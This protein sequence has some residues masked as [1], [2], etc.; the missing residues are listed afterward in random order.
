MPDGRG[1]WGKAGYRGPLEDIPGGMG[2]TLSWEGRYGGGAVLLPDGRVVVIGGI[3]I[4]G[5]AAREPLMSDG[6]FRP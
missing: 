5:I 1:G 3:A 2:G 4:G 6:P